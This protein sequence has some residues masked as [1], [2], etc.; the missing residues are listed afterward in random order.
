MQWSDEAIVLST[1]PHGE[2][3]LLC[4]LFTNTHG[5]HLG[6][7]RGG[8][9]KAMR[10]VCQVGNVVLGNW[11]ARLD[12]HL[13][14][15]AL[16][17]AEP[18]ASRYLAEPLPLSALSTICSHLTLFAERDPHPG[19]YQGARF[20]LSQLD[21]IN[22]WPGL[23]VRFELEVLSELGVGLDLSECAATGA[24]DELIYVSPKSGRA[25]S[26]A[27]GLPY[28]DKL[29]LLPA[30]LLAEGEKISFEDILA[31]FELTGAFFD[32]HFWQRQGEGRKTA[33]PMARQQLIKRLQ[34]GAEI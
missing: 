5:R 2:T 13:G 27:A 30:F 29:L 16:E 7:V 14:V 25:V 1:R 20:F 23:L 33:V 12:E 3:S 24:R 32:K 31:G 28:H 4:E 9:S 21:D 15:L 10:P 34:R 8:R 17:L 6:L 26:R 22:I 19:L 11:R 18:V